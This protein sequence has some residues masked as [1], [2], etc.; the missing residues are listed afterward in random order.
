MTTDS[1]Q[2]LTRESGAAT[3]FRDSVRQALESEDK[4]KVL[5]AVRARVGAVAPGDAARLWLSVADRWTAEPDSRRLALREAALAAKSD[6]ALFQF[7]SRAFSGAGDLDGNEAILLAEVASDARGVDV[8]VALANFYIGIDRPSDAAE[9]T[10]DLAALSPEGGSSALHLLDALQGYL[11]QSEANEL[12]LSAARSAGDDR[13]V[14][15]ALESRF[16]SEPNESGR[17]AELAAE[18]AN[19]CLKVT[20]DAEAAFSTVGDGWSRAPGEHKALYRSAED[21]AAAAEHPAVIGRLA[22]FAGELERWTEVVRWQRWLAEREERPYRKA[23]HLVIAADTLA[24]QLG[25]TEKALG[26]YVDAAELDAASATAVDQRLLVL[27][28]NTDGDARTAVREARATLLE[29]KG[30]YT[31]LHDVL[32]H[33]V[34]EA[35]DQ[36]RPGRLLELADVQLDRLGRSDLAVISL[37]EALGSTNASE[38]IRESVKQRLNDLL[39]TETS[40]ERAATALAAYAESVDDQAGLATSLEVLAHRATAP[41]E[42]AGYFSRLAA[43]REALGQLEAAADSLTQAHVADPSAGHQPKL[44]S[45][46]CE[47]GRFDDA[48]GLLQRELD[49][50][51]GEGRAELLDA[52]ASLS[53][54]AGQP[55]T[56]ARIWFELAELGKQSFDKLIAAENGESAAREAAAWYANADRP[57]D[58]AGLLWAAASAIGLKKKAAVLLGCLAG[59]TS[60]LDAKQTARLL[61]AAG[62]QDATTQVAAHRALLSHPK[63]VQTERGSRL[64]LGR[65]LAESDPASAESYLRAVVETEPDNQSA[66]DSLLALLKSTGDP[67]QLVQLLEH[68]L[69]HLTLSEDEA[70]DHLSQIVDIYVTDLGRPDLGF[71]FARSVLQFDP[72]HERALALIEENTTDDLGLRYEVLAEGVDEL[73]DTTLAT[74]HR[75]L[76]ELAVGLGAAPRAASHLLLAAAIDSVES[77]ER[78]ADTR[79]AAELQFTE[80][81]AS[82]VLE[83]F[84]LEA[85]LLTDGRGAR[86]E[87]VIDRLSDLGIEHAYSA[88]KIALLGWE[89]PEPGVL[90]RHAQLARRNGEPDAAVGSVLKWIEVDAEHVP[91]DRRAQ[92]ALDAFQVDPESDDAWSY[93]ADALARDP[94]HIDLMMRVEE[95]RGDGSRIVTLAEDLEILAETYETDEKL[96]VLYRAAE[97]VAPQNEPKAELIWRSILELAP[98][99]TR[100]MD[101]LRGALKERGDGAGETVLI[102]DRL[103]LVDGSERVALLKEI[104]ALAD[105][106]EDAEAGYRAVLDAS[107]DARDSRSALADL[108]ERTGRF[109]EAIEA[110]SGQNSGSDD[111]QREYLERISGIAGDKLGDSARAATAL[112]AMVDIDPTDDASLR[113]LVPLYETNESWKQLAAA[114]ERLAELEPDED[115]RA[116][117]YERLATVREDRLED[118]AGAAEAREQVV[119]LE[120]SNLAALQDVARLHEAAEAWDKY[121]HAL[122][123]I[124]NAANIPGLRQ[125]LLMRAAPVLLEKLERPSDAL[126]LFEQAISGGATAGE[127]TI[128]LMSQAAEQTGDW[129][130]W[131]NTVRLISKTE[132]DSVRRTELEIVIAD[133]LVERL[134]DPKSAVAWLAECVARDPQLGP[135]LTRVEE[136]ADAHDLQSDLVDTY[137]RLTSE[138]GDDPDTVWHAL[139]RSRMLAE[140]IDA[141]DTAFGI[142][143]RAAETPELAERSTEELERLAKEYG[144]WTEYVDFLGDGGEETAVDR[145]VRQAEIQ[146]GELKDWES[147]FETL[148]AAFQD[149]PFDER[150]QAPLYVLAEENSAWPLIAK[151]LELLQEDAEETEKTKYLSEIAGVYGDRLGNHSDAFAQQLRAWQLAP[152]DAELGLGL[153]SRAESAER[154]VDLLAAY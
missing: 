137:K 8:R 138:N 119:A 5:E 61:T 123:R 99:E 112:E 24:L 132:E 87:E 118:I 88:A 108:L 14:L 39:Q 18:L 86:A 68:R 120:P 136:I 96:P 57:Q 23:E 126:N 154:L 70:V 150:I 89:K 42:Q 65:L 148:V 149:A 54:K 19:H 27:E 26:L 121:V 37:S 71:T 30:N 60:P 85:P 102:R 44:R 17:I 83:S 15:A 4:S 100:A 147:A 125:E 135:T 130:R 67:A 80:R 56:A 93:C 12:V 64:A 13:R 35:D 82:G 124:A 73:T 34:A 46:L 36:S 84:A 110:L 146:S 49:A 53:L 11:L 25:E 22:E 91:L 140:K 106:D 79:K 51:E 113:K 153:R 81:D 90:D 40:A 75:Q 142:M 9:V 104:A 33:Q 32:M 141:P 117:L 111:E 97:L 152:R 76:A 128:E 134:D 50:N 20:G 62:K 129:A 58:A 145:A 66:L 69:E 144:L 10:R 41:A 127:N 43:T 78:V 1:L 55:G 107:P 29:G 31:E 52:Q 16:R 21:I 59:E 143:C 6:A 94:G 95:L 77:G 101:L 3:A 133:T 105:S 72:L 48:L 116:R 114:Q 92:L 45:L 2:D 7:L 98:G 28:R 109:E 122:D 47:V 115:R 131:C 151:L 38:A 139:S 74:R 63:D 103:N